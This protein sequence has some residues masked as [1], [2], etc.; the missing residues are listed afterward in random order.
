MVNGEVQLGVRREGA[1]SMLV[2]RSRTHPLTYAS[3][4]MNGIYQQSADV[5][6]MALKQEWRGKVYTE[7]YLLLRLCPITLHLSSFLTLLYSQDNIRSESV[8]HFIRNI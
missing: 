5:L 3:I 8:N 1:R 4:A 2:G 6:T 7:Q